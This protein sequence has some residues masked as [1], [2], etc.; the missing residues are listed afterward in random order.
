MKYKAYTSNLTPS[1]FEKV[2]QYIPQKK[3]TAPREVPYDAIL[4]A[5]FYRLH[6]GCKWEDLPGDFPNHKTVFH[7]A[8]AWKKEG[9]WDKMLDALKVENRIAQKK[10]TTDLANR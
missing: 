6:N 3:Q 5:I 4:D 2:A 1:Q 7:Y 8:N 10:R 9:V